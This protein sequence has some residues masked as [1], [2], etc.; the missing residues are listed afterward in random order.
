MTSTTPDLAE[1]LARLGLGQYAETCAQNNIEYDVLPDLTE[2]D[3]RRL[4]VASLGHRKKL[5]RAIEALTGVHRHTGTAVPASSVAATVPS[6]AQHREAEFR[7]I[8]VMFSDLVGST[9][10]SEQLDPEDL[11]KLIDAYR[12]ECSTAIKR[13]GGEV[14]RYFGDGEMA[15]F[16]WPYRHEGDA[17]P[18]FMPP[19]RLSRGSRRFQGQSRSPAA[20]DFAP[21]RLSSA[22]SEAAAHGRWTRSAR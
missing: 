4:G 12:G 19:W 21:G 18:A 6:P 10:L 15:F 9:Q 13:Y 16:G 8:T 7:Q 20:S 5:L 1:W 17:R 22:K 11:Q 14:A 2:N 3:L